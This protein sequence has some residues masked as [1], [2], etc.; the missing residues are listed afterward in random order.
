MTMFM[1]IMMM[2]MILVMIMMIMRKGDSLRQTVLLSWLMSL[3]ICI[4]CT[5]IC[6]WVCLYFYL[7]VFIF[8]ILFIFLFVWKGKGDLSNR[9]CLYPLAHE[10]KY[11]YWYLS[12]FIFSIVLVYIHFCICMKRNRGSLR[13]TVFLPRLM[14]RSKK[15]RRRRRQAPHANWHEI[16]WSVRWRWFGVDFQFQPPREENWPKQKMPR[17]LWNRFL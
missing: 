12:V 7:F 13:Q 14:S 9:L 3:G 2:T 17:T 15:Q 10:L 1:M 11:L 5:Y 8:V 4:S 16:P 6:L